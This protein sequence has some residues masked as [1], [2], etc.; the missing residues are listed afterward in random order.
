MRSFVYCIA[1]VGVLLSM[2]DAVEKTWD[3]QT[4]TM[5]DSQR[6]SYYRGTFGS[7]NTKVSGKWVQ[8]P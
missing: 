6:A 5:L 7:A 4:G 2:A 8:H 1:A 3:W